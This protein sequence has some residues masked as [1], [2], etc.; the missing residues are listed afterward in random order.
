MVGFVREIASGVTNCYHGR[1]I[2]E[3]EGGGGGGGRCAFR[4]RRERGGEWPRVKL[5]GEGRRGSLF[6]FLSEGENFRRVIR[7]N[8]MWIEKSASSDW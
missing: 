3:G 8:L 2:G 4:W 6:P 1:I 5:F 7:Q